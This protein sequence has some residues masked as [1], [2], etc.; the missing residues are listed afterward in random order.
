MICILASGD[1]FSTY[2][3]GQVYVK[4]I[5]SELIRKGH[6]VTV[7]SIVA[8]P[9]CHESTV[10]VSEVDGLTVWQLQVQRKRE[11]VDQPFELQ[12]AVLD[13]LK[14]VLQKIRPTVVHANGWKATAA[15]VCKELRIPCIVTAHHGGLVC[16]NGSLMNRNDEICSLPASMH[17]CLSCVLHFL[18]SG[19]LWSPV[20]KRLPEK[21]SMK[22]AAFLTGRQNIPYIS[23]S[24]QSP[25]SIANKL[26]EIEVLQQLPVRIIAP[27]PAIESAL[28]RNGVAKE[29][30]VIVSHGIPL[31]SHRPIESGLGHRPV[32][33]VFVGRIS[34]I[35]GVHVMLNAFAGLNCAQYELHIVGGAVT[36]TEKRYLAKL[37][38]QFR[39]VNATWYGACSQ[40]RV[41]E[42]LAACDVMIHPA[43]CL[44]VFGLTIAEALSVGRP[45][46]A[47]RCGGAEAQIRHKENGWL[48]PANDVEVL[49]A[50]IIHVI[51]K[52]ELIE[53][54]AGA[55]CTVH[56]IEDHVDELLEL[57]ASVCETPSNVAN[58]L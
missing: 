34:Y 49:R 51:E 1:Y 23:P 48:V 2:G 14:S 21:L 24:F 22:M 10:N 3:G 41:S 12:S 30:I 36:K 54:M 13:S 46:I 45:V 9:E 37:Q 47:S 40:D 7:I 53:Q 4:N 35:K 42:S 43:I 25:L 32:R 50:A 5:V 31:F 57:Y 17:N 44:E 58:C 39:G 19:N 38:R 52:P 15:T 20:V 55:S 56:T 29:K 18:P 6:Q 28:E 33:F 11:E 27:S 8:V 26:K 16:P